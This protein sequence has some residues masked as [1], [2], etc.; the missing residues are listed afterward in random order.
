MGRARGGGV[1]ERGSSNVEGG[2]GPLAAVA[3]VVK[4]SKESRLRGR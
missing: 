2:G 1:W 4:S 3:W